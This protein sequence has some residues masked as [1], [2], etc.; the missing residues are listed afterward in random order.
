MAKPDKPD[1]PDKPPHPP[2]PP[3]EVPNLKWGL[4]DYPVTQTQKN[5]LDGLWHMMS[6]LPRAY[7][8]PTLPEG[9]FYFQRSDNGDVIIGLYHC[10]V[11]VHRDGLLTINKE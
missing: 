3:E 2:D 1:K 11:S 8:S 6:D 4:Y 7:N 9:A 5:T 10:S